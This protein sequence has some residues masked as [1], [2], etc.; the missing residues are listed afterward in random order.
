M[1]SIK[2]TKQFEKEILVFSLN[3]KEDVF[4]LVQRYLSGERLSKNQFKT[5]TL[6]KNQKVQEF[7]VK[8]STGNWR[9]ISC[10]VEKDNLTF[11]YAFHKKS[12]KL[13]EK[14]KKVIVKRIK[15]LKNEQY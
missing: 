9:V 8:D 12:Q 5:F 6:G 1:K 14:D 15:E 3:V 10:V 13:L 4:L 2:Y 7:K 11:L